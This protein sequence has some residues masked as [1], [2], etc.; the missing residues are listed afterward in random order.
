M[1]GPGLYF[2]F[3]DNDATR[4]QPV[5]CRNPVTARGHWRDGAGKLRVVEACAEQGL[6]SRSEGRVRQQLAQ[7]PQTDDGASQPSGYETYLACVFG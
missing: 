3:V 1:L 2:R 7:G 5:P 6:S 4:G